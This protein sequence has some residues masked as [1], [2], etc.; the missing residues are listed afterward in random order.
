MKNDAVLDL[1]YFAIL[2]LRM[3]VNQAACERAFSQV[4]LR[5]TRVRNRLEIDKLKKELKVSAA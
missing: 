4:K 1:A 2:I 5:K 3:T